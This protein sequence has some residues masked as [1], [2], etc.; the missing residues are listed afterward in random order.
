APALD[1]RLMAFEFRLPDLGEGIRE[2]ELLEWRVKPG[3]AV[4]AFDPLCQVESA[5]A[6]VELTSPVEGTIGE[7]L[8]PAGGTAKVGE[9]LVT[10]E[11]AE[12]ESEWVGIVGAPPRP[13]AAAENDVRAAPLVRK[14]ARQAGIGLEDVK[15]TGPDG[16]VLVSDVEAYVA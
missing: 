11:T 13:A 9:V 3:D 10:I 5:K 16:R 6:A 12:A 1:G 8:V 14:M 4:R 7:T 2:A 15:G